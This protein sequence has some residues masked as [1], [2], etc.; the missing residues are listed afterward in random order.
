MS[1]ESSNPTILQS[2][3][4]QQYRDSHN[5]EARIRLHQLFSTNP[6]GWYRWYLDHL[7]LPDSCQI[8][9][10]GC[11]PGSLWKDLSGDL[12]SGW[13][14]TLTDFSLG[15]AREAQHN[16]PDPRFRFGVAD[17]QRLPFPDHS[18]DAVLANHMLYHVP[19]INQA[20]S[21]VRRVLR[22][23]GTFYAATNGE[24]HMSELYDL[25]F[26]LAPEMRKGPPSA[27]PRFWAQSFSLENGGEQ[28]GRWFNHVQMLRREDGLVVTQ[29]QPLVDYILSMLGYFLEALSEERLRVFTG[30]LEQEIKT[31]GAIYITKDTGLFKATL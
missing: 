16:L 20:L 3:L 6:Y 26:Q 19:D 22:P 10:L 12:P 2:L 30:A 1:T 17:A 9:E 11:G 28:I 29:A 4:N 21:E 15:M 18:F 8:L 31:K 25:E 27:Q 24:K 14:L 7:D 5:L 23:E 13:S